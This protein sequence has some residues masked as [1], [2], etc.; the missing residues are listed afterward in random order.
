[1]E[2]VK[3]GSQYPVVV[4][5]AHLCPENVKNILSSMGVKAYFDVAYLLKPDD[6]GRLLNILETLE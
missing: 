4:I 3:V 1:M 6:A 5:R 2:R